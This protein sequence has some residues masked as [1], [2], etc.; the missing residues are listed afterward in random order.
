MF[1]NNF[2]IL[3]S[4]ILGFVICYIIIAFLNWNFN[5]GEWNGFSRFCECLFGI[6]LSNAINEKIKF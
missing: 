3:Y 5:I 1:K 4:L 2:K 6:I